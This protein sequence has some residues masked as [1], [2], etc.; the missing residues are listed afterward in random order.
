MV[1]VCAV[2]SSSKYLVSVSE[3]A[4]GLNGGT[5]CWGKRRDKYVNTSECSFSVVVSVHF[6]NNKQQDRHRPS[7]YKR[8]AIRFLQKTCAA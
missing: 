7:S 8:P 1:M 3:V 4:C 5:N 2:N 6:I